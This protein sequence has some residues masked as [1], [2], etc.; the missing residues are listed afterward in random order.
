VKFDSL[1]T[2]DLIECVTDPTAHEA[3]EAVWRLE[4]TRLIAGLVR[5]V[6]DRAGGGLGSR[7]PGRRLEAVARNRRTRKPWR[8]ADDH[9][10]APGNRSASAARTA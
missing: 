3:I 9:S 8:V 2:R 4:S 7:G 5:I 1:V 6:R 10:Q